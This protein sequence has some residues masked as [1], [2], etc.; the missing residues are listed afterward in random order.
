MWYLIV[1]VRF[2]RNARCRLYIFEFMLEMNCMFEF[3]E[4]FDSM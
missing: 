4:F 2:V 3:V 1:L